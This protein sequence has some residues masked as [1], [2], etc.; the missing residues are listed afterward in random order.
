MLAKT[1][2]ALDGFTLVTYDGTVLGSPE[3]STEGTANGNLD[4]NL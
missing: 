2:G 3:D 4:G 1:L